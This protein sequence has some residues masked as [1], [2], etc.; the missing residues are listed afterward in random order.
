MMDTTGAGESVREVKEDMVMARG[1][2]RWRCE[3][4]GEVEVQTTTEWERRRMR[5]RVWWGRSGGGGFVGS[6]G[7]VAGCGCALGSRGGVMDQVRW[8]G[9]LV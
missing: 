5:V 7:E 4:G 6:G 3:V 2:G 8:W 9:G 1:E